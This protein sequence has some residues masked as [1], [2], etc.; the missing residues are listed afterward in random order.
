MIK[1]QLLIICFLILSCQSQKEKMNNYKAKT[2][3]EDINTDRQSSLKE[4]FLS[5]SLR[6]YV[7][8]TIQKIDRFKEWPYPFYDIFF[9]KDTI[10]I[11]IA[12]SRIVFYDKELDQ[13]IGYYRCKNSIF[14]II[15][16]PVLSKK[17]KIYSTSCLKQLSDNLLDSLTSINFNRTGRR[18]QELILKKTSTG[19]RIV[20]EDL[21]YHR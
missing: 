16:N 10:D 3:S 2:K 1:Y 9:T 6:K 21:D 15:D 14:Q 12:I 4:L 7:T 17:Q 13:S 8:Y 5:D 19:Y 20:K 11:C 18:L